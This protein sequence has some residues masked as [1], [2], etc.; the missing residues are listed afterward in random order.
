MNESSCL[1][2]GPRLTII[3]R[4]L[5]QKKDRLTHLFDWIFVEFELETTSPM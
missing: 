3:E 4:L 5:T 2:H 1:A